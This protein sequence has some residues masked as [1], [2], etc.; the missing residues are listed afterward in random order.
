MSNWISVLQERSENI[1]DMVSELELAY[2][3]VEVYSDLNVV[4]IEKVDITGVISKVHLIVSLLCHTGAMQGQ[5]AS[6]GGAEWGD[7]E[8]GDGAV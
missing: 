3:C 7:D 6:P 1:E 2:N 4:C 8:A 5:W